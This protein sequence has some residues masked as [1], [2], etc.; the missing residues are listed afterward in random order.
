MQE[1]G[2]VE[3]RA[4]VDEG[5]REERHPDRDVHG[6]PDGERPARIRQRR[7]LELA[8]GCIQFRAVEG[9]RDAGV[10]VTPNESAEDDDDGRTVVAPARPLNFQE[11][12]RSTMYGPR[13]R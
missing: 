7:S 1:R 4:D 12:C 9:A 6:V 13:C 10:N 5:R 2:V 8:G 3:R 11:V